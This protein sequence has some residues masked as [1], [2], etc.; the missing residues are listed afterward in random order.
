MV[1]I[2]LLI[3]DTYV[4]SD[5]DLTMLSLFFTPCISNSIADE[6]SQPDTKVPKPGIRQF[7]TRIKIAWQRV[8]LLLRLFNVLSCS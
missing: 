4:I 8:S 3:S 7:K 2:R 1:L 5:D 6:A